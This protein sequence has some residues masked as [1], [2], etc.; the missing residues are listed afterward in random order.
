[1]TFGISPVSGWPTPGAESFP[2]YIQ[3]QADGTNLGAA[4]AHTLNLGPGLSAT[5]GEGESAG[6]VTVTATAQA[7]GAAAEVLVFTATGA[8]IFPGA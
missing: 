6:V 8:V 1:M 3:F 7:G 2:D 5:R 4:D